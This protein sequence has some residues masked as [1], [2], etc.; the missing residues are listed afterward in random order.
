MATETPDRPTHLPP[1][2]LGRLGLNRSTSAL[3]LGILLIGMGQSLWAPYMPKFIEN[4]IQRYLHGRPAPWGLSTSA[5]VIL[6]VGLFGTLNDLQ[7]GIYYYL[8]GRLGGKL[9]TR[10]ALIFC[11]LLPMAGYGM[12][13]AWVSP[14]APFLAMPFILAYDSF[15]QPATLTV[16]GNTLK[17]RHRTMAFSLQ[18]IQRRI[19]RIIAYITGGALV[20]YLGA[21][22]GVRL[23]VGISAVLVLLA[24]VIQIKMLR[25]DT[26]DEA[27]RTGAFSLSLVRRFHPELRKLLMAD[28]L[29][30][31]AEGLPRE[32][33][34]LY[35]IAPKAGDLAIPSFGTFG[36]SSIVFG[37][38]IALMSFT[39]LLTYIPVGYVAS[40]PGGEK[41]PF[42]ASTFV[43][44]AVFPLAFWG[45]GHLLGVWGLLIAYVIAGLRE[46]GEPARKA[47]ITELLPADARTAATGLYWAIRS[48]AVMLAPLLGAILWITINPAAVFL[49]AFAVGIAGAIL[50]AMLFSRRAGLEAGG[51]RVS[52]RPHLPSASG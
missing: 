3:L 5:F 19:P 4:T 10:K 14:I 43:F 13:L 29:A 39:S 16:V 2:W 7:E 31:V 8:G 21:I 33:L 49:I 6:A 42:I 22:G 38:L 9:G 52:H 15:S 18:A 35:V 27:K 24:I 41:K 17:E 46:I 37:Q 30:R 51:S 32:L 36:V 45:L 1:S 50:F 20:G 23:S 40:R 26:R 34:I 47:M 48:F 11:S 28:I 12:L 25:S 44:F